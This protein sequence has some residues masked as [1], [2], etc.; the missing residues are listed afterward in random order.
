LSSATELAALTGADAGADGS[1]GAGADDAID[2]ATAAD[3]NTPIMDDGVNESW[4]LAPETAPA[5]RTASTKGEVEEEWNP[6]SDVA[7]ESTTW[8]G[9]LFMLVAFALIVILVWM[10]F[11]NA[12]KE[13]ERKRQMQ[14]WQEAQAEKKKGA[15]LGVFSP[16][17]RDAA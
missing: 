8:S 1:A 11:R 4:A 12:M 6:L 2:P 5:P 10:N 14:E 15:D 3:L 9:L 17:R 7:D 16:D 13:S